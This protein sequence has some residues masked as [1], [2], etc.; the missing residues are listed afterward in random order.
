MTYGQLIA[1]IVG[2]VIGTMTLYGT[3]HPYFASLTAAIAIVLIVWAAV[4]YGRHTQPQ[5]TP[6]RPRLD[7]VL[8]HHQRPYVMEQTRE[9]PETG[10][11]EFYQRWYRVGIVSDQA[12]RVH[13]LLESVAPQS[14]FVFPGHALQVMGQPPGTEWVDVHPGPD[15]TVFIDVFVQTID[16]RSGVAPEDVRSL[17]LCYVNQVNRLLPNRRQVVGLRVQGGGATQLRH[18]VIDFARNGDATFRPQ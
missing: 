1:P 17:H 13:V 7:I 2:A 4:L 18:F 14:Q 10:Y 8:R 9:D 11:V 3:G 12:V 15:P 5:A 6:A 16:E